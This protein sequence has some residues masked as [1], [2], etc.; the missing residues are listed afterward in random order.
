MN[1]SGSGTT[2]GDEEWRN[3]HTMLSCISGMV[4]KTK[5][6]I[7]ILQHRGTD[8]APA[9]HQEATLISDIKRQTE[10]KIAEF[11]R[12]AEDAVNQVSRAASDFERLKA[13]HMTL[14]FPFSLLPP[15]KVKRQAVIEI[16]RAVAAA[17]TRA[18]DM[19]AQERVKM[20]KIYGE[21]SRAGDGIDGEHQ[22]TGSNVRMNHV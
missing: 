3:I 9:T 5:R 11:R 8:N 2:S 21:I 16:Q 20:E 10:E 18:I 19:I 14:C 4:E 17:E 7:S 15:I 13:H 22:T 6:A 1:G 12:N